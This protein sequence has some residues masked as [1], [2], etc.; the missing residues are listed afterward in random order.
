LRRNGETVL[1]TGKAKKGEKK[2]AILQGGL[3]SSKG[4]QDTGNMTWIVEAKG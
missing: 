2:V 4:G 1:K 3:I